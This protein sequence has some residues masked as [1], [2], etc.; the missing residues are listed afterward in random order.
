MADLSL[1]DIMSD[2]PME[3]ESAEVQE[4]QEQPEEDQFE[5]QGE[6]S[7]EGE[8]SDA[9]EPE[10]DDTQEPKM[11]PLAALEAEREKGRQKV[12][13]VSERLAQIEQMLTQSQQGQKQA[14]PQKLPDMFDQPEAYTQSLMQMMQ[15][16]ESNLIAEMSER[17]ARTQHGSEAVDAAFE[18]A[19]ASGVID[20]FRGKRDPWGDLVQW[21]KQHQVMSE[22]GSDPEAWRAKERE[23]LRQEILA[24]TA[25]QQIKQA[26][27]R[28][29]PSLA[30]SANLGARTAPAW[31]GPTPLDDILKG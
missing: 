14:E 28:P 18:A 7:P 17:F 26:S 30:G 29:A 20:Q 1:D 24:E 19:K 8:D 16:R 23:R 15:Q 3:D 11:V 12:S 5:E 6:E 31:S 25:S 27:A 21:H 9:A 2:K 13:A 10:G 4:T 22:I